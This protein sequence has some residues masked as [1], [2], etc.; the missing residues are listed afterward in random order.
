M[1]NF[2]INCI[3]YSK[4]TKNIM[5]L[6][7]A[8]RELFLKNIINLYQ[9]RQV[10]WFNHLIVLVLISLR[11]GLMHGCTNLVVITFH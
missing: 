1:F 11:F 7:V 8:I 2:K 3:L 9:M 4:Y 6:N 5:K 10:Y